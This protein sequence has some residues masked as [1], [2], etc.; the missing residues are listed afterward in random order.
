[1]QASTNRTEKEKLLTG[2]G[3]QVKSL[4]RLRVQIITWVKSNDINDKTALHKNRR[5]IETVS[6]GF[7]IILVWSS[8]VVY[9]VIS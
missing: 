2:L 6:H 4:W 9:L 8:Y 7:T 3:V 1:M 5:L